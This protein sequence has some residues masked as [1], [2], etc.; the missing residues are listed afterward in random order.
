MPPARSASVALGD[1]RWATMSLHRSIRTARCS[2]RNSC[3]TR[4]AKVV[5]QMRLSVSAHKGCHSVRSGAVQEAR[6][7]FSFEFSDSEGAL[8]GD[9]A[10]SSSSACGVDQLAAA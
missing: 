5:A 7:Y 10:E 2:V 4:Q 9:I 3:N 6:T 1:E 8:R